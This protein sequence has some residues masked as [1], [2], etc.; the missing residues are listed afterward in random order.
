MDPEGSQGSGSSLR[1]N[2]ASGESIRDRY[3]SFLA[4]DGAGKPQPLAPGCKFMGLEFILSWKIT[5]GVGVRGRWG[6][7]RD[8]ANPR[9]LRGNPKPG[10]IPSGHRRDA[11]R[12]TSQRNFGA[13]GS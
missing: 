8:A 1:D 4:W 7:I 10:T 9:W 12:P 6:G 3:G 5:V 11:A 2:A 13:R